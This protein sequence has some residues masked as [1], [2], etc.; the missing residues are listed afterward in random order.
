[1]VTLQ[2]PYVLT[3]LQGNEYR[4]VGKKVFL[5]RTTQKLFFWLC[6]VISFSS[7]LC[8]DIHQKKKDYISIVTNV[9]L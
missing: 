9:V 4:N 1:M 8:I 7:Y 2:S 3:T 6:T 5:W